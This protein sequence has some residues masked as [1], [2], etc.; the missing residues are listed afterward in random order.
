LITDLPTEI[1]TQPFKVETRIAEV[2][3]IPIIEAIEQEGITSNLGRATLLG[4][5]SSILAG[6]SIIL[7]VSLFGKRN[8]PIPFLPV[9]LN[10]VANSD[11]ESNYSNPPT[12]KIPFDDIPFHIERGEK[13]IVD[14]SPIYVDN[15]K[16]ELERPIK[17]VS[18]VYFLTNAG[19]TFKQ[20]EGKKIGEIDL[21]F[22]G[23]IIQKQELI[24][25][26]NIREWAPG[27][28]APGE[29][30]DKVT[31]NLSQQ[32]WE[33][34]NTAGNRAVI[35]RLEVIVQESNRSKRL[36]EIRFSRNVTI[37]KSAFL[38]LAITLKGN[39]K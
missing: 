24:L 32:I 35:D 8:G 28:M 4:V 3:N 9:S 19:N 39:L 31:E 26:H 20:N 38:I 16:L 17:G 13:S 7:S 10:K 25:G 15:I 34:E 36:R 37:E 27:N 18:S 21:I 33:G 11:L 23:E 1:N 29:L 5:I 22:E 14:I 12:G 30:V 6:L 2:K